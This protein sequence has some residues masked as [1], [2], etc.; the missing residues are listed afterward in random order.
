M[1]AG[2][3]LLRAVRAVE[4]R[5][6]L[7]AAARLLARVALPLG[8]VA[9]A[10][11]IAASRRLGAPIELAWLG[12]VPF[13]G[14]LLYAWLR[15][16]QTRAAARRL[17]A[18]YGLH[19]LIGNALE[20][21]ER[22]PAGD[23]VAADL[24]AL[25][26]SDAEAAAAR[27]DP[28]PVV[29][30]RLPGLRLLDLA[31]AALLV[32][33]MF[34]PPPAPVVADEDLPPDPT[35][36]GPAAA[37]R[38][39]PSDRA[40]VE[41]LREDLR[42]LRGGAD[43]A[44]ELAER[45][46][47]VLDAYARGEL[48]REAAYA[49]LE[50]L[51]R[52]LAEAEADLEASLEEDPGLLAEG[53]RK[54]AEALQQEDITQPA[55]EALAR[56]DGDQAEKA[57]GD[58]EAEAD[59]SAESERQLDRAMAEAERA[60][61]KAAGENTDTAAQLAE[62]ERRLRR[63]QQQPAADPEEQERRLKKLKERVEELRRQHEREKAAQRKLEQLRRDAS[64]AQQGKGSEQKKRALERLRR[65][66][67][68]AARKSSAARRL[69][70]ARDDLEEAKSFMRRA[71]AG[72]EQDEKRRQQ[73]QKFAKAAKGKR[74]DK[75]Q[76]PTLLV[77]GELG[78]GEPDAFME[79]E[80]DD[81]M[82]S[83]D[84]G[85]P[86]DSGGDGE[87]SGGQSDSQS[88]G[89]GRGDGIGEGSVSPLADPSGMKTRPK[90]VRVNPRQG[91]GATKAEIIRTASQEGFASE[92]YRDT[93]RDYRSFAQ[94]SLDNEALPAEQRRRVKRYFQLIQPRR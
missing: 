80:G 58:A 14:V 5:E 39:P 77:E 27:L 17:D 21:A 84:G 67:G 54:L 1:R 83:G 38:K 70:Q 51:E 59:A 92:S 44:A 55:G 50:Q 88:P 93:Y 63:Q 66:A 90:D 36:E 24:A 69:G 75:N 7:V 34:V 42:R 26:M 32:L 22:P 48:E 35:R 10:L 49:A 56:G 60:L 81:G 29:P 82:A 37:P 11:A 8:C 18:Y 16:R 30:L 6:R 94:S 9:A 71:G 12:L 45:M 20:F 73:M 40:M 85:D 43:R 31:A 3:A 23:P 53:V 72:G 62:A 86:Q 65:G 46:L 91:K 13:F 89:Q 57:L 33:A 87:D 15:P 76:G 68:E 52:E 64:E 28:R 74:G 25:Q 4:R 2:A 61:G 41:P 78:D 47:A 79:G 19:D